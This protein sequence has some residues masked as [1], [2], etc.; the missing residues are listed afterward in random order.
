M[1]LLLLAAFGLR[2]W[3]TATT[4][5]DRGDCGSCLAAA[6][7]QHDLGLLALFVALTVAWLLLPRT[8][9]WLAAAL[10]GLLLLAIVADLVTLS[11]FSLRLSLRDVLKFGA[12]LQAVFGYTFARLFSAEGLLALLALLA[13]LGFWLGWLR[14]LWRGRPAGARALAVVTVL[15]GVVYLLPG[16][17]YHPLPWTYRNLLEVNWPSGVDR[18]YSAAYRE[19]LEQLPEPTPSCHAGQATGRDL[20]VVL[21]ESWSMYHGAELGVMDGTPGIDGLRARG[22]SWERFFSNGFTTDHGLIALLGGATPLPSVNRYRSLDAFAGFHD[23]PDSLPRRLA[24]DGYQSLFFTSGDL[25]FLGKGAWLQAIG[26]DH[27]EGHEQAYYEGMQRF[28][29]GAVHDGQLYDRVLDWLGREHVMGQPYVAVVETV[30]THPPFTHPE[31]G[32]QD[33]E[34]AFRFADRELLRFAQELE[35]RGFFDNGLLVVTSDQRALAAMRAEEWARYGNAAPALLPMLVLG[36]GFG[37]G[38]RISV[39]GQMRDFPYSVDALLTD[40]ACAL[41]GSGLL[42]GAAP[43]PPGC[44]LR[45]QG[46]QRDI[47]D[48][49]CGEAHVRI[50]LDGDETQFLDPPPPGAAGLL[51]QVN[52]QRIRQGELDA[53]LSAIL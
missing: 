6:S 5:L 41:P 21:I 35:A 13:L 39:P 22:T 4:L 33:E 7:V 49:W 50:E 28:A 34:G 20:I 29:F 1:L 24:E 31:T 25:G 11:N 2:A 52:R 37:D 30:T 17:A 27:V 51:E 44:I 32:E 14:H 46:N 10:Q 12:E 16:R 43:R 36:P 15:A 9:A 53:D 48:A 19:Q 42:F 18:S 45:P 40:R 38:A 8:L 3:I 26:F 23:L 47:V